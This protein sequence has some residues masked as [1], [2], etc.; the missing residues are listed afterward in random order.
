MSAPE[1]L[2]LFSRF[3]SLAYQVRLR[4]RVEVGLSPDFLE[5]VTKGSP[6]RYEGLNKQIP[7]Y[8]NCWVL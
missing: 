6:P 3:S 2:Y 8:L 5:P 7:K 4:H 1:L